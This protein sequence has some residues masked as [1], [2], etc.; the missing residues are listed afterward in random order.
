MNFWF[1]R[2]LA[3]P[4]FRFLVFLVAATLL[5]TTTAFA[6]EVKIPDAD[7]ERAIRETL[8]IPATSP[9]TQQAMLQLTDLALLDS[10]IA[11]LTGLK[12]ATNLEVL[13][14]VNNRITDISPLTNLTNLTHLY[15]GDNALETIEPLAGL[16]NL[17]V[18]DLYNAGV[19][20]ITP[21]ANLTALESLV[22]VRN[23][24]A[25]ISPLAGLKNL[26]RLQLAENPIQDFTPLL[27]LDAVELDIEIDFS[28]LDQLNLVV[29]IPDS[30]LE[31]AIRDTLSL[32]DGVSLTQLEMLRLQRLNAWQRN[33]KDLTGLQYAANLELLALWDNQ[34]TDLSP[35][36]S[37]TK[38][39]ELNLA[40]NAVESLEPIA[41]LINLQRLN[42][43]INRVQDITPLAHLINLEFLYIRENLVTDITPIQ[44]LNLIDFRY[45]EICDF[46]PIAPPVRER[47]ENRNFPSIFAWG[48]NGALIGFDHLTRNQRIAYHDLD[49]GVGYRVGW[50]QTPTEP[51]PGLGTSLAGYVEWGREAHKKQLHLNPN[52]IVLFSR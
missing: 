18:L 13:N 24:I 25:D 45:D 46:P 14:L 49:F 43:T 26:K 41:G 48:G 30:N 52:L 38:L 1:S 3:F 7:L 15:L 50:D 2:V 19:K 11:D 22:I 34:I 32:P 44:G 10:S 4:S 9:I 37:L 27:E 40:Y 17:R 21:L 5:I 6:Q 47:M 29:T 12:Y 20:D 39:T 16:I 33:I 28:R 42:L 51:A 23:M 36:A 35:L 31:R 8:N